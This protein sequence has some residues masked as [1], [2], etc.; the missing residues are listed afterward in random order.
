MRRICWLSLLIVII[1]LIATAPINLTDAHAAPR[2]QAAGQICV[3]AFSDVNGDGVYTAPDE[4][5]LPNVTFV[6]SNETGRLGTYP[7]DG[8]SEPYCFGSL[9]VGQ[10]TVQARPDTKK[11]KG[12]PTTP[13]Q[14]VV[15]L[16]A[17]ALYDISYGVQ[18]GAAPAGSNVDT[19]AASSSGKTPLGRLAAG[20]LG[21]ALFGAAGYLGYSIVRRARSA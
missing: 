3:L 8:N 19:A 7:T 2:A 21:V 14:W 11:I 16:S 1:A 18:L 12:E 13:G 9:A 4:P 17:G 10:Y 6:L 20:L 15:P 5:L